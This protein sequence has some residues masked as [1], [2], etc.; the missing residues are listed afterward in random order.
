MAHTIQNESSHQKKTEM[1]HF[2]AVTLKP[3][4]PNTTVVPG[5][6]H[7]ESEYQP[8]EYDPKSPKNSPNPF[9]PFHDQVLYQ[10]RDR[11][12][13]IPLKKPSL[14]FFPALALLL[15]ALGW[16]GWWTL[17]KR[18]LLALVEDN[19]PS[20]RLADVQRRIQVEGDPLNSRIYLARTL[21]DGELD[22]S[23]LS[24]LPPESQ[25]QAA[26]QSLE[27]I[28][29]ARSLAEGVLEKRSDSWIA[30]MV[31]GGSI[32]L[33]RWRTG[34]PA[35]VQDR[36]DWERPLS[37]AREL[38]PSRED[39]IRWLAMAYL[40]TWDDREDQLRPEVEE[41]LI[42]AFTDTP[43]LQRLL[44]AWLTIENDPQLAYRLLPPKAST[45]RAVSSFWVSAGHFDH[46]A[47]AEGLRRQALVLESEAHHEE[48][49]ARL[50]GGDLKG[51]R[52]LYLKVTTQLVPS[53]EHAAAFSRAVLDSPPGIASQATQ[54]AHN[55][56]LNWARPLLALGQTPLSPTVI[57]RLIP[58]SGRLVPAEKAL[59]ALASG[60]DVLADRYVRAAPDLWSEAWIPY[61]Q[62]KAQRA[63]G[64]GA[65]E[66][67]RETLKS[68]HRG[69]RQTLV[70]RRLLG[71]DQQGFSES[72]GK[73][74]ATGW[75]W[76]G[77]TAFQEVSL[78]FEASGLTLEF[79]QGT[80]KNGAMVEIQWD[81]QSIG[82][83]G[84]SSLSPLSLDFHPSPGDHLI[85]F[86]HLRGDSVRP[87]G[88]TVEP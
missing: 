10:R 67:G 86:T 88:M 26:A 62:L 19:P 40:L 57:G 56:W 20:I 36:V 41:V 64:I 11:E 29:L 27:N 8:Q 42:R 73:F 28:Q 39:P 24:E 77:A 23:Y 50:A 13:A 53:M 47:E 9:P 31:L 66:Q 61:Y 25:E 48:A 84:L 4:G 59:F 46:L 33:E 80:L 52:D 6:F 78:G 44:P 72:L 1:N 35:L 75:R 43:T 32:F 12:L 15:M 65:E 81:G 38:A 68:A 17:E 49:A 21:L 85:T 60:D 14:L 37:R 69:I 54:R 18:T 70:Y 22:A 76:R 5:S 71:G 3:K 7:G 74:P 55:D 58:Q 2:I 63:V 79:L 82:L 83:F 45:W 30:H 51:A 87:G 16:L 34:N